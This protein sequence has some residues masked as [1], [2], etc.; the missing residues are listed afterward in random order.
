M[1][2][3]IDFTGG[4]LVCDGFLREHYVHMG[5]HPAWKFTRVEEL[6]FENGALTSREDV[7]QKMAAIREKL[8]GTDEALKAFIENAFKLDY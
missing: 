6:I 5:F 8:A 1:R 3:P 4:L 7:S 2:Y